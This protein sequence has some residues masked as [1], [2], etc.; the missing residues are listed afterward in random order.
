MCEQVVCEQVRRREDRRTGGGRRRDT[1]PKTRTPHKDVGT[2]S[3]AAAA[4]AV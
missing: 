3:T 1:E 4:A 2:K